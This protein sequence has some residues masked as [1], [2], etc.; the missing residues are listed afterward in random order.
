MFKQFWATVMP[1]LQSDRYESGYFLK[2]WMKYYCLDEAWTLS[3]KS[4]RC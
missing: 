1:K 4:I 2:I 3:S